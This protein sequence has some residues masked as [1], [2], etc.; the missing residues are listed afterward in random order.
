M[1]VSAVALLVLV[2]GISTAE[3]RNEKSDCSE[4]TLDTLTQ[5]ATLPPQENG[6]ETDDTCPTW[7]LPATDDKENDTCKCGNDLD[8]IVICNNVTQPVYLHRCYCMSY[9]QDMSALV[10]G[11]CDYS[12]FQLT[13][14]KSPIECFY[15]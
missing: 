14:L 10:V 7:F 12:C 9:N 1:S 3:H 6:T 5:L 13:V 8:S 2:L 11:N 4:S 15:A